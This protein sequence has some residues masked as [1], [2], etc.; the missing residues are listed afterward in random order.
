MRLVSPKGRRARKEGAW[1][2][3]CVRRPGALSLDTLV[4]VVTGLG[5]VGMRV[6]RKRE[7]SG[8]L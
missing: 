8:A 7:A 4:R 6:G 3:A 2:G 5:S 1:E